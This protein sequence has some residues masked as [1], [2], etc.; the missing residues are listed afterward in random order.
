M[1]DIPVGVRRSRGVSRGADDGAV[2]SRAAGSGIIGSGLTQR[3]CAFGAPKLS[4]GL[5]G[6]GRLD[7]L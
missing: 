4:H 1:H 2:R 7:D 5:V 3:T 6:S